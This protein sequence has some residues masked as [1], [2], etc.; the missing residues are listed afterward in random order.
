MIVAAISQSQEGKEA[1]MILIIQA[2]PCIIHLENRVGE[3]LIKV[4]LAMAAERFHQ[5]RG[6]RSLNQFA[7]NIN[8]IVNTSILGAVVRPKQQKV[9]I[10][11]SGDLLAMAAEQFHQERGVR[12]LNQFAR[13]IIHIVNTSILG[14]IVR[15]KQQKVPISDS[16]GGKGVVKQQQDAHL[17]TLIILLTMFVQILFMK[18]K[19]RYGSSCSIIIEKQ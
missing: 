7:R 9:P 16:G 19:S 4:L 18:S 11:D 8:H 10:S 15:P 5:E 1:A 3:E 2:I 14:A 13:N 12:S 17:I 6:V